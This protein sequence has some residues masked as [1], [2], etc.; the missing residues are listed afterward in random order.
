MSKDFDHKLYL[1]I[2]QTM[3]GKP[4]AIDKTVEKLKQVFTEAGYVHTHHMPEGYYGLKDGVMHQL[5]N[6]KLFTGPEFY[7][8]FK[9]EY[10]KLEGQS[11]G[12]TI[13]PR[14]NALI[15]AKHA[16]GIK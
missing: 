4:N 3:G 1:T 7:D 11:K 16:A 9:K 6:E 15:A 14:G 12:G 10:H 2:L 13:M 8:K 5:T